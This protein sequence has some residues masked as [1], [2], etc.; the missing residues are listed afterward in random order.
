MIRVLLS[1]LIF[2]ASLLT[3]AKPPV[4][5]LWKFAILVQEGGHYLVIPCLLLALISFRYGHLGPAAS[6]MLVAASL[7]FAYPLGRAILAAH[8]L[9]AGFSRDFAKKV[10][11]H[12]L[13]HRANPL[14]LGDLFL[15]VEFPAVESKTAIY[16][17]RPTGDLA[18]DFYPAPAVPGAASGVPCV[19]VVHG[20]GWDG[21][22][23]SQLRDLNRY[24]A[25]TGYAVAAIDY[26]LAPASRYPAPLDDL[27]EAMAYLRRHA[28]ELGIDPRRFVLLGRS[29]GGQIAQ[30]AAYTFKDPGIRGVI[31]FYSP[32][33]MVFGYAN[34]VNPLI[35]DSKALMDHY[36]GPPPGD[37][38][39]FAP[40][41]PLVAADSSAPPT[42]LLHGRPDVIVSILH[43]EHLCG[44]LRSLGVPC[45]LVDLPWATHGFDYV[46][47]GPGSQISLYF[48]ER[49]LV[50]VTR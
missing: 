43:S 30:Q 50:A 1:L 49:F 2:L 31:A 19:I 17:K 39:R 27:R 28:A 9:D 38:A 29:A 46:F 36:L 45:F 11:E 22:D 42:L 7:L 4:Y 37:A 34:P 25:A 13:L 24:L 15:G 16:A 44:K 26:R 41:S 35:L 20:G 40:T 3:V 14:Q 12:T 8:Q 23:R 21:G 18:L 10:P 6:A 47:R 32:A 48:I 33:D 5:L